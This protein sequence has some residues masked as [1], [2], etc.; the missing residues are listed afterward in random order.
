M[1]MLRNVHAGSR[2]RIR[3]VGDGKSRR[4][5]S[6]WVGLSPR[7]GGGQEPRTWSKESMPGVQA[8]LEVEE[9]C[10]GPAQFLSVEVVATTPQGLAGQLHV[11][12]WPKGV[13]VAGAPEWTAE[14]PLPRPRDVRRCFM[15]I[16][17]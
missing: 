13:G 6:L 15:T 2:F 14:I 9:T 16:V 8:T 7:P 12:V 3:L 4:T 1:T 5:A 11:E 17:S 10:P